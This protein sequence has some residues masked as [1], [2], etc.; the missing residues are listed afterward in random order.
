MLRDH[1]SSVR[2]KR[3]CRLRH[4]APPAKAALLELDAAQ[5]VSQPVRL[6]EVAQPEGR[7]P[8]YE[9]AV[10]KGSD[11]KQGALKGLRRAGLCQWHSLE[12]VLP[13]STKDKGQ[14]EGQS[15]ELKGKDMQAAVSDGPAAAV[16]LGGSD[17]A[18]QEVT[19]RPGAF[20]NI[21][22]EAA[23]V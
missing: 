6:R 7:G 2:V 9:G 4:R 13:D 8:V 15:N 5:E 21:F 14:G 16:L 23:G 22:L 18:A 10:Y 19:S 17:L 12:W 3:A 11:D 20:A 1:Q